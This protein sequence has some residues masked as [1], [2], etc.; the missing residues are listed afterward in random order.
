MTGTTSTAVRTGPLV[1]VD[2]A[3]GQALVGRMAVH[4]IPAENPDGTSPWHAS[5]A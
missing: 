4:V 3:R 2:V 5:R 1:G